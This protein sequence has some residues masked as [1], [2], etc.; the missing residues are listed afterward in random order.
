MQINLPELS[1]VVLIGA[2]SSGKS[3]F[4]KKHFKATE[5][6]S[7]DACRALVSD[8]ENDLY[9]TNDAFET[10]HYIAGK[11][12]KRGNLTVIDATSTQM[13][14]R[15]TLVQ[16][17]KKY[18]VFPIAIVF[19][20]PFETLAER[21]A[22]RSD[23]NF[24]KHVLTNHASQVKKSLRTLKKEGFREIYTLESVQEIDQISINRVPLWNNKKH[25]KGAFD[26][27]GDVHGCFNE[28]QEL[29]TNLGYDIQKSENQGFTI[30][31]PA[32]RKA[33][34]VGDL[35]DRG[36]NS[37][38]VLRLV[39]QMQ[40]E[41]KAFCVLGNH[42]AKL[43]QKLDGKDVLLKHGLAETMDQ[44]GKESPEFIKEVKHFLR[45]LISH[46][47]FD[48]GRL[49]VAHAGLREEMQGRG[50]GTVKSFCMYGETT[51]EIDEFGLP[52]R[53]NWASEYKG[54]A[55][56]VYGHTPIPEP[57]WLNYTLN[58]DTGCVFGGKLTALRYPE[59]EIFSVKAAQ[60]YAESKRPFL[61]T[62][63]TL[64]AQQIDDDLLDMEDVSGKRIISTNFSHNITIKE[65]NS[66]AALEVMSR[67][68]VNPKWLI[69]L[70][71]TMSPCA[72]SS[73]AD[74]LEYPAQA[75]DYFAQENV[76]TV[77]CEQKHMGSRAVLVICKDDSVPE[78]RFGILEK[79]LG[80]IYTRTG[81][82]FFN[83]QKI[84]QKILSEINFALTKSNF[85]DKFQ[86]EWLCLD[87]ELM[88]WSA[89]A[90]DLIKNQF[91]AV[92]SSAQ[93]SLKEVLQVFEKSK[94]LPI[95]ELHEKYQQKAENID[96]Y[97]KS[98]RNY[99]WKIE[100]FEDY[101]VAPFHILATE[102]AVHHDKTHL[103]HLQQIADFCVEEVK[104][105]TKTPYKIVDLQ[106][107]NSKIEA[108]NWWLELTAKGFEGMVVKPEHFLVKTT[109]GLAQ[110]AVKCRGKEYLRIIYGAEYTE[111][112]NL[113]TL[114]I[115]SLNKKRALALREFALGL[116]SLERFVK[117]EPLRKVH[118]CVFGV[119]ALESEEVDPRL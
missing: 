106:D 11:R 24:G 69:Y 13:E 51:G 45:N 101:K 55:M 76:Q 68:A 79:S 83:D 7:S 27:I 91:A 52:V 49:V 67:F 26:I 8:N 63:T 56:V 70:P 43:L 80:I 3:T 64:S 73:Q 33:V 96:K 25:E 22:T 81:R 117:K 78:K 39:M 108:T 38:D 93:N 47:V 54:K 75:F 112:N 118:E 23:R 65:E 95:Q 21:H 19:N 110:P 104:I 6:I 116:E 100:N 109:K 111:K 30:K 16:L 9:A 2:S 92:G 114:K 1:L 57:E 18:H 88:P 97:I 48:E 41:N 42:D 59:K 90:Q 37:P 84:E 10:L 98:Y 50:S 36:Y 82:S 102:N 94:H 103:W 105:L 46:Y 71:P 62:K 31:N 60:I 34:F 32:N 85:W 107:E 119:L 87:A 29:L 5:V 66:I 77:I 115:R 74:F 89:K 113:K 53:Y 72:T 86:T 40:A 12:I 20:L 28:L 35:V 99:C 4:C 15:K 17:A 58:I 44:L 61:A 14:S